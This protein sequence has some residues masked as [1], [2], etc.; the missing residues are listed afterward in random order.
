MF[1]GLEGWFDVASA[2]TQAVNAFIS[3]EHAVIVGSI[4]PDPFYDFT[5]Q[6]PHVSIDD[7]VREIVWPSNEF[8]LQRNPG[9]RDVVGLIGV[10]PHLYWKTLSRRSCGRRGARLRGRRHR[11]LG[12]RGDPAQPHPR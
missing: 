4:D 5:Q 8:V 3:D 6:R 9:H 2:A 10:E 12:R 1:V 11:G 7:D